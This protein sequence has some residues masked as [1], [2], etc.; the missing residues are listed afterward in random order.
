MNTYEQRSN[1]IREGSFILL[2]EGKEESE[3]ARK[4]ERNRQKRGNEVNDE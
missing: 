1:I 2:Y 3:D 4:R